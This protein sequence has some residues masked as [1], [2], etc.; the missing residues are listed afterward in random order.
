MKPDRVV[1]S[2]AGLLLTAGFATWALG[3]VHYLRVLG[4]WLWVGALAVMC[5][6][7]LF[8]LAGRFFGR[9]R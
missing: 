4:V 8:L 5:V 6:P 2:L 7:L 1:L 9:R 3:G